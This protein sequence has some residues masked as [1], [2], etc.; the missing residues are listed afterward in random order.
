MHKVAKFGGS[1]LADARQFEKVKTIITSDPLRSTIVVSAPGKRFAQDNKITDLFYL[2]YEHVK[3]GVAYDTLLNIIFDRF[4]T[5]QNELQL[6]LDLESEF[7]TIEQRLHK[8]MN[9]D[10]L[11]SRGEYLCA[12][13]LASYLGYTFVDAANIIVFQYD[14]SIDYDKSQKRMD[15]L[16]KLDQN[17]VVPG[18]YGAHENGEIALMSR[19][20][21]DITGSILARLTQAC[22]YENWTDV[23]GILMA[24]PRIVREPIQINKITHM[25]L[26]EL[27]YMGANILHDETLYPIANMHIPIH[28]LNTNDPKQP[29]TLIVE[30]CEYEPHE[31]AITG[32]A[33]KRDF[34]SITMY[35]TQLSNEIGI[36]RRTLEIFEQ[37]EIRIEHVTTSID[38]FSVMVATADFKPFQYKI[39]NE[40]MVTGRV[41]DIEL[42]DGISLI[43]TVG[44]NMIE[45][46]GISSKL[47]EILAKN[48]I[49]LQ[50][51]ALDRAEIN[52]IIGVDNCDHDHTIQAIYRGFVE[53]NEERQPC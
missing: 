20:G 16:V 33:G 14:S 8:H 31:L 6:D 9:V 44:R 11:V 37:Y 32:I 47:F 13:L 25:E 30:E 43:A 51:I 53:D 23:T 17:I 4:R 45:R 15:E 22:A 24:D 50:L 34:T 48:E 3:Y 28:I 42:Q 46:G 52:M 21:S 38:S 29:G 2:C 39:R 10:Y 26:R 27:S 12:K 7:R 5:I 18:F 40:I 35:K 1:S 41:D 49:K 19:G 36:I